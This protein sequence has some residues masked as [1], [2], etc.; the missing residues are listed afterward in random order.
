MF[1]LSGRRSVR[2]SPNFIQHITA[3]TIKTTSAKTKSDWVIRSRST[4]T[5]AEAMSIR[6]LV[7]GLNGHP[8]TASTANPSWTPEPDEILTPQLQ[9]AKDKGWQLEILVARPVEF[10][11]VLPVIKERLLAKPTAFLIGNGIRGNAS[12]TEF[13]QDL[14]NASRECSPGT[15]LVFNTSPFDIIEA[16][17]RSLET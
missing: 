7:L 8:P 10:T 14:V 2:C 1:T 11:A 12:H 15:L 13:F 6:I 5:K 9:A 4:T 16:C 3:R 17:E